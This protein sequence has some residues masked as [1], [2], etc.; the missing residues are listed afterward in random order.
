MVVM[1]DEDTYRTRCRQRETADGKEVPDPAILDMKGWYD[2][3]RV[4]FP[5]CPT[6]AAAFLAARAESHARTLSKYGN[7]R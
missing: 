6:F 7:F 4:R 2:T 1:A 3:A 5:L